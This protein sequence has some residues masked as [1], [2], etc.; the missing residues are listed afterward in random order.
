MHQDTG[1]K[2]STVLVLL[3]RAE[4]AASTL[5]ADA[6]PFE[7]ATAMETTAEEDNDDKEAG[8]VVREIINLT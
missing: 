1:T 6:P 8:E 5:S 7:P 2:V 4:A 3:S